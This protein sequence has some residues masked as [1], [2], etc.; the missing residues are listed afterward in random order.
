MCQVFGDATCHK[1]PH[2]SQASLPC[3]SY[4]ALLISEKGLDPCMPCKGIN[5]LLKFS[6]KEEDYIR[7]TADYR[8]RRNF[9]FFIM[10]FTSRTDTDVKA[11]D[12]PEVRYQR[13]ILLNNLFLNRLQLVL[14]WIKGGGLHQIDSRCKAFITY[15]T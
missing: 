15:T 9:A 1:V 2:E 10:S 7:L 6:M 11:F 4:F 12:W 3:V 5:Y 13:K 14:N 8:L